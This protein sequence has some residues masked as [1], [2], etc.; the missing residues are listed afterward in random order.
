[1]ASIIAGHHMG[2]HLMTL[3]PAYGRDYKTA[4]AAKADWNDN[5]D[6]VVSDFFSPWDGQYINKE[7]GFQTEDRNIIL[8]FDKLRKTTPV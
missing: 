6:F 2:Y 8:R 5:K 3:T 7:L 4:K 1:M